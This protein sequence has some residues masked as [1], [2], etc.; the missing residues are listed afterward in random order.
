MKKEKKIVFFLKRSTRIIKNYISIK[1]KQNSLFA[2]NKN[3]TTK[4]RNKRRV[5]KNLPVMKTS[6]YINYRNLQ[7]IEKTVRIITW[8]KKIKIF[9]TKFF[10]YQKISKILSEKTY[11]IT[12]FIG[13]NN[14]KNYQQQNTLTIQSQ[15]VA[16]TYIFIIYIAQITVTTV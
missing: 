13:K 16:F 3:K 11:Y 7:K 1:I 8:K 6:C 14:N 5:L 2:V 10:L 9:L 4:L 15:G 12:K